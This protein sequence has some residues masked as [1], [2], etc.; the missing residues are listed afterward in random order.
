VRV[1]R[2]VLEDHGDVAIL[3]GF[4]D[5]RFVVDGDVAA[6]D[7]FQAGEHAQQGRFAAAGRADQDEKFLV[8]D[9]QVELGNDDGVAEPLMHAEK[10]N[11]RH[12]VS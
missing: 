3:G 9:V 5:D 8:G 4:G 1:Q 6:A 7:G 11:F 12:D 10:R 2:V